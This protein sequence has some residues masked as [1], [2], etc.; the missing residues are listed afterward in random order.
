ML[1]SRNYNYVL[2]KCPSHFYPLPRNNHCY[3]FLSVLPNI[4]YISVVQ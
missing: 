2:N 1:E 3:K 4:L